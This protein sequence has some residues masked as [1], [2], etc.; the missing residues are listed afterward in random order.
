MTDIGAQLTVPVA[1]PR[2][3]SGW[4]VVIGML[5][6]GAAA[7]AVMFVYWDL[8]TKP[9]RPL[10]EAIGRTYKH[11]LPK[12]EGGRHKRGPMTLR[13]A[14]RVPF[15]PEVDQASADAALDTI[16]R[17]IRE[18]QDLAGYDRV[19]IHFFQMV[20]EEVAKSKRFELT[21]EEVKER[22]RL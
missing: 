13:V 10:T 11:S 22:G 4:I 9:F 21:P 3:I 16:C 6:T 18:H 1:R 5:L 17:L 7:T 19:Q 12:V 15:S 2:R 14:L 20:P 8:H